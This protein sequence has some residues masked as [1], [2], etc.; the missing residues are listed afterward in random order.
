MSPVNSIDSNSSVTAGSSAR[1]MQTL[2][3]DDFLKIMITELTNQ[4]P[5]EPMQNQDLLNQMSTI[6]QMQSSQEMTRSFN[7]L[8]SNFDSLLTRQAMGAATEMIG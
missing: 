2:S 3:S 4:D 1:D 7:E 8:M 5:L 6:Q